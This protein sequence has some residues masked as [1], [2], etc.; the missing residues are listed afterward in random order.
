MLLKSIIRNARR[1]KRWLRPGK[2]H[3]KRLRLNKKTSSST[4]QDYTSPPLSSSPSVLLEQLD[5]LSMDS[6]QER[7]QPNSWSHIMLTTR[8]H[9]K[10]NLRILS[11]CP[12]TC[13]HLWIT[14]E[15][16]ALSCSLLLCPSHAWARWLS[17][18]PTKWKPSSQTESSE[19]Q[20]SE[21][22]SSSACWC[23]P[24]VTSKNA[25]TSWE[26]TMVDTS[27]NIMMEES[28]WL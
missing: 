1:T 11:L 12:L 9:L 13:L 8:A 7:W 21:S 20:S 10:P 19:D 4:H 17:D 3:L 16:S 18:Q 5:Q 14:L 2:V 24:R 15:S 25:S 23:S 27:T 6:M 22:S 26:T 28:L